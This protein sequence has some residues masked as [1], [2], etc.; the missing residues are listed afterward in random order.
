MCKLQDVTHI[1]RKKKGNLM[2][3]ADK[4][5]MYS[6][7]SLNLQNDSLKRYTNTGCIYRNMKEY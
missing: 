3:H 5:V 7:N 4:I 6:I 1:R 2:K